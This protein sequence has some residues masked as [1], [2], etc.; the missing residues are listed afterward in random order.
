MQ[1]I[2]RGKPSEQT[3]DL[4]LHEAAKHGEQGR[5]FITL[6]HEEGSVCAKIRYEG[7]KVY[8]IFAVAAAHFL[9]EKAIKEWVKQN[10]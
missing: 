2:N 8:D 7:E 6:A 4:M 5:R 3:I 1:I 9:M 10:K